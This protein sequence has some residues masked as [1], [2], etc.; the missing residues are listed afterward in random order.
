M[1][2]SLP[3]ELETERLR[4]RRWRPEDLAPFAALNAVAG[5]AFLFLGGPAH[6]LGRE[7][8]PCVRIAGCL[9][10]RACP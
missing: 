1:N 3:R 10:N 6:A 2:R 8:E 9:A 7:A 5:L 4:L